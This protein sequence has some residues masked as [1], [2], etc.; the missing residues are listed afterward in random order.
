MVDRR[1]YDYEIGAYCVENN[2]KE[3]IEK[4][5]EYFQKIIEND[6]TDIH[7]ERFDFIRDMK[8][9]KVDKYTYR[10]CIFHRPY[11]EYLSETIYEKITDYGTLYYG[12]I[13]D[14]K[15]IISED[16]ELRKKKESIDIETVKKYVSSK[17]YE[18]TKQILE[19]YIYD[20]TFEK[21]SKDL[22]KIYDKIRNVIGE[23]FYGY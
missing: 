21:I 8:I 17:K 20:K 12:E 5:Y 10:I 1:Y 2:D 6:Y 9:D 3:K 19:S 22:D 7:G 14:D 11:D 18:Y 16:E 13:K 4:I 23:Q 15:L